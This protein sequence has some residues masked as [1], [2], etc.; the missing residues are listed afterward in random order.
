M[1]GRGVRVGESECLVP[2]PRGA[3]AQPR[4]TGLQPCVDIQQRPVEQLLVPAPGV[5]GDA[6]PTVEQL[7]CWIALE[8]EPAAE[9]AQVRL[10]CGQDVLALKAAHLQPVLDRAQECVRVRERGGVV[11]ADVAAGRERGEPLQG[12]RHPQRLVVAPVHQL[13]Q[14]HAEL[15]VAQAARAELDLPSR[16]AVDLVL[17]ALTQVPRLRDVAGVAPGAPHERPRLRHELPA[18]RR[19][20]AHGTGFQQRLELPRL[21]PPL[22][23][24]GET[25]QSADQGAPTALG[26]QIRVHGPQ[27][28]LDAGLGAD[29]HQR[30]R[31]A[32][33]PLDVVVTGVVADD[34]H[35]VDVADVVQLLRA[36]L[37]KRD[38]RQ[39]CAGVCR[40]LRAG[41]VQ[42]GSQRGVGEV[43]ELAP[44]GLDQLPVNHVAGDDPDEPAPV[45]RAHPRDRVRARGRAAHRGTQ[46][47]THRLGIPLRLPSIAHNR[48]IA[49]V[50]H[51]VVGQ[52]GA[53]AEHRHQVGG[54]AGVGGLC[55][56]LLVGRAQR[57]H[58]GQRGIRVRGPRERGQR[59]IGHRTGHLA[60][61][62]QRRSGVQDPRAR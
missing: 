3:R 52:G 53:C 62:G 28:A 47:T 61:R 18:H 15:H 32:R 13:Q 40:M 31:D 49:R 43:A 24:V 58:P 9:P 50:P 37:S 27:R 21:R 17:R 1:A 46:V 23:V 38:H 59:R 34:E 22:V 16:I 20:T 8:S 33:G 6:A 55:R 19:V 54:E 36:A 35:H 4:D 14:L 56:E 39:R 41:D 30:A 60:Q 45:L 48:C 10:R 25:S 51:Q 57:T 5:N 26:A 7:L 2:L 12:S 42:C 29:L 44:R 11:A